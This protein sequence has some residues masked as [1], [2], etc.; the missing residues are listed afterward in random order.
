MSELAESVQLSDA[1]LALLRTRLSGEWVG[2]TEENRPLYR[3]L[4][5]AGL[6][7]PVSTFLHGKEG[8][9]RPTDAAL[10][11]LYTPPPSPGEA[12]VP[13]D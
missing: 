8:Y 2:V 3:E 12:P 4:V 10:N 7:Y 5:A 1:A 13:R 6:M 11:G 9:Y